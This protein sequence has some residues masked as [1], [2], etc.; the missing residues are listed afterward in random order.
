M[1]NYMMLFRSEMPVQRPTAE[2]MEEQVKVWQGWIAKI[3]EQGKF[4]A[5]NALGGESKTVNA[6]GMIT[7]GP[8][9]ESKEMIGGYIIVKTNNIDEATKLS[10]GCPTLSYGGKVEVRDIMIFDN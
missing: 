8:C 4:V 1:K 6:D 7:D 10:E 5:T 9:I 3:A 2:Q